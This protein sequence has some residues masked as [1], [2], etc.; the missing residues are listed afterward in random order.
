LDPIQVSRC[1]TF[2]CYRPGW[3]TQRKYRDILP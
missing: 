1:V 3:G 2:Y